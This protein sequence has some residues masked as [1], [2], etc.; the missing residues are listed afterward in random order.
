M[1]MNIETAETKDNYNALKEIPAA[2]R[3]IELKKK[4]TNLM[5]NI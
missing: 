2:R 5:R 1:R 3:E 4:D